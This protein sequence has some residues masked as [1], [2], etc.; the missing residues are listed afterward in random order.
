MKLG[1]CGRFLPVGLVLAILATPLTTSRAKADSGE[2][3]N[4]P[5][6]SWQFKLDQIKT[7]PAFSILALG[8]FTKDGTFIGTAGPD[9]A[10]DPPQPTEGPAHG[11]W[12]KTGAR[13][14]TTEFQTLFRNPN[15]TLFGIFHRDDETDAGC[16]WVIRRLERT[17]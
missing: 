12:V 3:G 6:G 1:F 13:S 15:G 7:D 8:T 10:T 5:I 2:D 17:A 9:G 11:A 4:S 16:Q 14:S